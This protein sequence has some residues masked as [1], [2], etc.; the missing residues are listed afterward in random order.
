M[1][2]KLELNQGFERMRSADKPI[3]IP[4]GSIT[5]RTTTTKVECEIKD[6]V[7]LKSDFNK[8]LEQKANNRLID[9]QKQLAPA[10][11]TAKNIAMIIQENTGNNSLNN[12]LDVL[13][14]L[15]NKAEAEVTSLTDG[16]EKVKDGITRELKSNYHNKN[17]IAFETVYQE[18]IANADELND[19]LP[20]VLHYGINTQAV[21]DL[22]G[23]YLS[24]EDIHP[25]EASLFLK[26]LEY[27]NNTIDTQSYIQNDDFE[28][29]PNNTV[30]MDIFV[31][32]N[33]CIKQ[34]E[35]TN[36][37]ETHTLVL[38]RK[39]PNEIYLIDPSQK[40]FSEN[41]IEIMKRHDFDCLKLPTTTKLYGTADYAANNKPKYSEDPNN[42][43][44]RDCIDIAVKIAFELNEQ[45]KSKKPL[46]D[47]E[48]NMLAQISN[49]AGNAP[50]LT[51]LPKS[52]IIRELQ[53]SNFST[54]TAAKKVV[55]E[56]NN[57]IIRKD[58]LFNVMSSSKIRNYCHI[59]ALKQSMESLVELYI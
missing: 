38:W 10:T 19:K 21:G 49:I 28:L 6:I 50:H 8:P 57:A 25:I 7:R 34:Y 20:A 32:D 11:D 36:L 37:P 51:K 9:L 52:L 41:F 31:R 23:A 26:A 15:K 27:L 53:S 12:A 4:N 18:N 35:D 30:L 54:R 45:Q 48:K 14:D 40:S 13:A 55:G 5:P 29:Y 3:N 24:K 58:K 39:K 17:D 43:S 22:V 47:I 59:L 56:V 2:I 33:H 42:P 46:A 1:K 44:P 16:I